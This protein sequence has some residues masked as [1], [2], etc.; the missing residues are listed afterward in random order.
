MVYTFSIRNV[1]FCALHERAKTSGHVSCRI[2]LHMFCS[3]H[4]F[5]MV[6]CYLAAAQAHFTTVTEQQQL[7]TL[8]PKTID[9]DWVTFLAE[10]NLNLRIRYWY[11]NKWL[12]LSTLMIRRCP[13]FRCCFSSLILYSLMH[14]HASFRISKSNPDFGKKKKKK[15]P[16]ALQINQPC[17][18]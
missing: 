1:Y 6:S 18:S 2:N 9:Q 11:S 3:S 13:Y 17:L 8:W 10:L 7:F 14:F 16:M 15:N 5:L 4:H 12:E